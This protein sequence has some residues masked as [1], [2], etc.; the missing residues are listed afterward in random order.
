MKYEII[1]NGEVIDH[2]A[3]TYDAVE[4]VKEYRMAF[5]SFNVYYRSEVK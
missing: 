4:L 1:Y 2:A 3:T 5:K